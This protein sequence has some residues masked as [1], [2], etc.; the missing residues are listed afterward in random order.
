M[1]GVPLAAALYARTEA[2]HCEAPHVS[3]MPRVAV[4][5]PEGAHR[6]L[7]TRGLDAVAEELLTVLRA[8]YL[9][10][11]FLPVCATGPLCAGL[12][13]RREQWIE[14]VRWTLE[15]AGAPLTSHALSLAGVPSS[16]GRGGVAVAR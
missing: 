13:V 7:L 9:L 2:A 3:Y 14:L 12:G 16:V 5:P 6:M 11:L 4:A 8:L 15:R 1:V 10:L